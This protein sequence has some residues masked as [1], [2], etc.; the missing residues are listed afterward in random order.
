MIVNSFKIGSFSLHY[1]ASLII[2]IVTGLF[3]MQEDY[4]MSFK[5]VCN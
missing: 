4:V 1:H 2:F 5:N 3:H